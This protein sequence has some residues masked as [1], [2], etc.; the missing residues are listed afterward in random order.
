MNNIILRRIVTYMLDQYGTVLVI[1]AA[2]I[3]FSYFVVI[4][5][6]KE[7]EGNATLVRLSTEQGQIVQTINFHTTQLA[8]HDNKKSISKTKGVISKHLA[9]L[10]DTH[11][12]LKEGD[13][14]VRQG[15]R[16]THVRGVLPPELRK[17]YSGSS[18]ETSLNR[19]MSRYRTLVREIVSLPPAKLF[20]NN[21]QL[22]LLYEDISPPLMRNLNTV[23]N[24]YQTRTESML[25]GTKRKQNLVLLLS[26]GILALLGTGLLRPLVQRLKESNQKFETEK[27]FADNVIN[28]AQ[29]L[30]IGLDP[31]ENIVLFNQYAE[32]STGWAAE[33]VTGKNF[34]E[35]FVSQDGEKTLQTL[36]SQM[37]LGELEF[38]DEVETKIQVS[39]GEFIEV[40]WHSTVV[41]DQKTKKTIMFLATGSDITERKAVEANLQRTHAQMEALSQRLQGEVN[42]AATL[43]QSILP[44]AHIELPGIQGF[45]NLLTSS[46]V[47]GDYYDYYKIGGHHSLIF[48]GDVSGHGVAAGTMVSA[49]KASVYPLVHE[50]LT[51]PAH[52]LNRL[53]ET[54]LMTVQ[55]SLLMT[56]NCLSLD[57][58]TGTL[59]FAN[60]GHVLPYLWRHKESYWE[61]LE[62]S[63]LPLGK[64][65][66]ADYSLSTIEIEMEVGDRLFLFTDGLVEE[67]SPSG[68]AFGYERLE[69][70]LS[71]CGEL[72]A[73]VV[74]DYLLEALESHC[75]TQK[76]EDDVSVMMITHSD[77]IAEDTLNA[78]D[79]ISDII[80][81]S[82]S[83]Y[84]QG[85]QPIPRISREYIV[86]LAEHNFSDLLD[87]LSQD[88]ICR[89][90][91]KHCHFCQAIGWNHLLSQHHETHDDDL[92]QLMPHLPQKRQ[93]QLTHTDDKL[94]IMEEI[95][96]W[97]A[98]M[99]T[100][101]QEHLDALMV[102][103][104]EMIENSF[105][106]APR[107]GKGVAYYEK[108]ESRE[109][110]EH[111]E[112]RIDV[113]FA[114]NRLG[115][116]ITDN[117]GTLPPSIFLKKLANS[118]ESGIE[119]GVGGAGLYMMWRLSDYFQI[120]VHPQHKTQM[121]TL[122]DLNKPID[123]E[124][125]SGF[126]FIHH[127]EYD[128]I[129]K[130]T[131]R[132]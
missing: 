88:G 80:R 8:H 64:S 74:K 39:T 23:S 19:Q 57:A 128:P 66:D 2:T 97:L 129:V 120:R 99:K 72:D 14:F 11:L 28:T 26:L 84:R 82:E 116:M 76:F 95:L 37:M 106:A 42:L 85:N 17:I 53:N 96:S 50:G 47:G 29:A 5:G 78:T 122:W 44:S 125:T 36:F 21:P 117:W 69:D 114:N 73:E 24:F 25:E 16:I 86:F 94:F 46:E 98:D 27:A 6:L 10:Q 56:M 91:P 109:L 51:H 87:R 89:V 32:E 108:G 63:G 104:D 22:T 65:I 112:V 9:R 123:M 100:L 45:A 30:I 34:F 61:M 1:L 38:S 67:E 13:R 12:S 59:Q 68:E 115:V 7:Q 126:Q 131:M 119:A 77:R 60:A 4:F 40:I 18:K 31:D 130:N 54:L 105:Y 20:F 101:P 35:L 49:A 55:Q 90:L 58:R 113:A 71:Q 102:I 48:I 107:D 70:I 103:L 132:T 92:Y 111:E 79:D 52:I 62:A 75:E 81:V 127:S 121:T 118:M 83:A 43:Q 33:E 124:A 93:F 41:L 15:T 3:I 110:S